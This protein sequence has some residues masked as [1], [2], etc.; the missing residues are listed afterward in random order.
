MGRN[1]SEKE[2]KPDQHGTML[3][4][5]ENPPRET[6]NNHLLTLVTVAA[7]IDAAAVSLSV[8]LLSQSSLINFLGNCAY[9]LCT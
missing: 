7:V 3:E 5:T 2:Q 1:N 4:T 9:K 8:P 6:D